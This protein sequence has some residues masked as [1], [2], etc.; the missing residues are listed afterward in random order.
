VQELTKKFVKTFN[1]LFRRLAGE[2]NP[3]VI[4]QQ[5]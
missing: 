1:L 5:I 2:L 3:L 4:I